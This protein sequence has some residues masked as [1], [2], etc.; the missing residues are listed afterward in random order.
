MSEILQIF[1][2][3][4]PPHVK[5]HGHEFNC[6][7]DSGLPSPGITDHFQCSEFAGSPFT[8]FL[9]SS[10]DELS[11][12]TTIIGQNQNLNKRKLEFDDDVEVDSQKQRIPNIKT[13]TC[14]GN[15]KPKRD[16]RSDYIHVR[17]RRGEATDNHSLAER[18]R[19][20]KIKKRMQFLQD[21]V[22]GCNKL[23]NKAAIL[24]EIITYV[25][26]LQMEVELLTM[27]LAVSTTTPTLQDGQLIA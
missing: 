14:N 9:S 11:K 27:Q 25:Q 24:D 2:H 18:A 6:S 15:S 23:T 20:E 5:F 17:A 22:P 7:M 19:R 26:C 16:L 4:P 3:S 21:M 12:V 13:N 8:N 1:Q 10:V